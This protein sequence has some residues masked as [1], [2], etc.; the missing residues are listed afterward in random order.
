[1]KNLLVL[2]LLLLPTLAAA[3][4][5]R[6]PYPD[7]TGPI[8]YPAGASARAVAVNEAVR[9]SLRGK[10]G[11]IYCAKIDTSTG[12]CLG[13]LN[14]D[15]GGGGGDGGGGGGGGSGGGGCP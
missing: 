14:L 2:T 4:P 12:K 8:A 6:A 3:D 9:H 13:E 15:A 10:P 1:M 11:V 5:G 7:Y